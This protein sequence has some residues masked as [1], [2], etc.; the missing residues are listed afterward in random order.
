MRVKCK[1]LNSIGYDPLLRKYFIERRIQGIMFRMK[2]YYRK[3][4]EEYISNKTKK[5][6]EEIYRRRR[7]RKKNANRRHVS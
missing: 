4:I 3:D 2:S 6:F 1:A 7:N 5:V